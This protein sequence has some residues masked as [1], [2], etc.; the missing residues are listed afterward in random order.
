MVPVSIAVRIS[1]FVDPSLERRGHHDLEPGLTPKEFLKDLL[2]M[3][4]SGLF[5]GY[6]HI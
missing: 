2:L 4:L 5:S 1:R 3:K 6:V